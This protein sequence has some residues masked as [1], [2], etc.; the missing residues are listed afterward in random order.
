V[1]V[2]YVLVLS[3]VCLTLAPFYPG[4]CVSCVSCVCMQSK[5]FVLPVSAMAIIDKLPGDVTDRRTPH[6]EINWVFTTITDTIAWCVHSST[7]PCR[8]KPSGR[9]R[10]RPAQDWVAS[11]GDTQLRA[12]NHRACSGTAGTARALKRSSISS[13]SSCREGCAVFRP[14]WCGAQS[15]CPFS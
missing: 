7:C 9:M 8:V 13:R 10:T 11:Q 12:L 6:G 1:A 14:W 4:V 5:S 15:A 3:C 2:G